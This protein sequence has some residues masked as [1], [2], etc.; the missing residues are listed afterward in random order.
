V[1]IIPGPGYDE[2]VLSTPASPRLC[3]SRG[4]ARQGRAA[5]VIVTYGVLNDPGASPHDRAALWPEAWGHAV[6]ICA[7]CWEQSRQV[8][9]KYR[10]ALAVCDDTASAAPQPPIGRT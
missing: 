3:N 2:I 10:P 7:G 5:E 4:C 8:A 6:P 9:V 1:V